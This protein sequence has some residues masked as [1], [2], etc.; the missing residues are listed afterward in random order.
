MPV[1]SLEPLPQPAVLVAG[2]ATGGGGGDAD[3]GADA[4]VPVAP[5]PPPQATSVVKSNMVHRC[6][7]PSPC[8]MKRSPKPSKQ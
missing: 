7:I 1:V 4:D 8:L 2:A 5:V 6:L 3:T